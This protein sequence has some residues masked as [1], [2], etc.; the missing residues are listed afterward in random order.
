MPTETEKCE[1]CGRS[2]GQLEEVHLWKERTVCAEC[3]RRLQ[4]IVPKA[5]EGQSKRRRL[6]FLIIPAIAVFAI[7]V[8]VIATVVIVRNQGSSATP[9]STPAKVLASKANGPLSEISDP[10]RRLAAFFDTRKINRNKINLELDSEAAQDLNK[11]NPM[12]FVDSS[13]AP[14]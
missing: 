13:A 5:N 6:L 4:G 11:I 1:N 8:G 2:I 10:K 12:D 14:Q 9:T 7:I 3:I